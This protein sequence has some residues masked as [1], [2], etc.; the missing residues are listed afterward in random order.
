MSRYINLWS[1]L[2][3]FGKTVWEKQFRPIELL[4]HRAIILLQTWLFSQFGLNV[5]TK[6]PA[7]Q[8]RETEHNDTNKKSNKE[9]VNK[10]GQLRYTW[11]SLWFHGYK[12]P[13]WTAKS[14]QTAKRNQHGDL[15]AAGGVQKRSDIFELISSRGI[16][17]TKDGPLAAFVKKLDKKEITNEELNSIIESLDPRTQD[18][19]QARI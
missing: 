17:P 15:H 16:R 4:D 12:I 13:C 8:P 5:V 6:E 1:R 19:L 2:K 3:T 7:A 14:N 10:I 11:F 9:S 18:L